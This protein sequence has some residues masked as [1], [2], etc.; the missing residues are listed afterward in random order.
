MLVTSVV[1]RAFGLYS[2]FRSASGRTAAIAHHPDDDHL[3]V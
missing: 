1:R 3:F 2:A